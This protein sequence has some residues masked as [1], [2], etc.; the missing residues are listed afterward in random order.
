[1]TGTATL[2]HEWDERLWDSMR[3]ASHVPNTDRVRKLGQYARHA[4]G[5]GW[6]W[7]LIASALDVS[8]STARYYSE[9]AYGKGGSD[10]T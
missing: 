9:H 3:A 10:A 4:R 1:M 6:S 7:S 5:R 2:R 8:V